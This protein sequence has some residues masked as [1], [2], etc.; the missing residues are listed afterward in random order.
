M[1]QSLST[2][3]HEGPEANNAKVTLVD[4]WGWPTTA[5][6]GVPIEHRHF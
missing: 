3:V 1:T 2:A 6:L 4:F 5:D